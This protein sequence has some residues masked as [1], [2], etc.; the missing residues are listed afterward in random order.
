[1]LESNTMARRDEWRAAAR[2]AATQTD[3]ASAGAY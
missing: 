1:M 2:A 3:T